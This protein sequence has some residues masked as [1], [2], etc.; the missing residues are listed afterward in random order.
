MTDRITLR[1][2]SMRSPHAAALVLDTLMAL[3]TGVYRPHLA[4]ATISRC[5]AKSPDRAR[6]DSLG[7]CHIFAGTH[8]RYCSMPESV[9]RDCPHFRDEWKPSG[10][11]HLMPAASTRSL[12][13][14]RRT[15]EIAADIIDALSAARQAEGLVGAAANAWITDEWDEVDS[16]GAPT[17]RRRPIRVVLTQRERAQTELARHI[18]ATLDERY[19]AEARRNRG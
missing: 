4:P 17:K 15:R 18:A 5:V 13:D 12:A 16:F 2:S 10:R 6:C 1:R 3:S 8:H 7:Y 19:R 11:P 14:D 9:T